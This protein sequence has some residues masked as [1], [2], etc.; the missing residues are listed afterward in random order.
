MSDEASARAALSRGRREPTSWTVPLRWAAAG[1][2]VASAVVP[3]V[4]TAVYLNVGMLERTVR[5]ANPGL[6]DDQVHSQATLQYATTW[7][8]TA[9]LGLLFVGLAAAGLVGWRW[10]FWADLVV[11]TLTLIDSALIVAIPVA[12]P[13]ATTVTSAVLLL[14]ALALLGWFVAAAFRYGPWAMRRPG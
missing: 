14:A 10:V 1:Y 12:R 11:V 8:L 7:G 5:A 13:Q 6:P 3:M 9:I 4:L 2:L